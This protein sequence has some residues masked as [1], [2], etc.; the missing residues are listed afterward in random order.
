MPL[1][2]TDLLEYRVINSPLIHRFIQKFLCYSHN[3]SK[4]V[5]PY[6]WYVRSDSWAWIPEKSM[7]GARRVSDLNSLL[8]T[9]K[10]HEHVRRIIMRSINRSK[11]LGTD[12]NSPFYRYIVKVLEE[13]HAVS[14]QLNTS[15]S[16]VYIKLQILDNEEEVCSLTGKG[17]VVLPSFIFQ[18]DY[19]GEEDKRPSSRGC[20]WLRL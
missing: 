12:L 11:K 7:I 16:D 20:E 5:L 1:P 10:L 15:K 14:L 9:D 18:K 3:I 13:N 6:S 19:N 2:A 4:C 17:H 8:S